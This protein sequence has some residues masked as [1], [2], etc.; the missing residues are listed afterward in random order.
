MKVILLQ[1]VARI[2]KK[3][4]I[5]TVPDGFAQNKLIPKRLAEPATPENLK[6]AEKTQSDAKNVADNQMQKFRA[7]VTALKDVRVVLRADANAQGHLFKAIHESDIVMAT[8][9]IGVEVEKAFVVIPS[10]IKS[11]GEHKV[12]LKHKDQTETFTIKVVT[13]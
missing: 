2:G 10:Q 6:K 11:L 8:S 7:S 5:V 12:V 4:T 3:G 1:D 13:K 9:E